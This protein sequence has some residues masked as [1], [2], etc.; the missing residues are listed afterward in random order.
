MVFFGLCKGLYDSNIFAALFDH[1]PPEARATAAG[2]MNTV[3]WS[4]GALGPLAIGFMSKYG[5]YATEM[6]NMSHGIAW[7]GAI[8]VLGGILLIVAVLTGAGSVS[9]QPSKS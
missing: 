2:L 9:Q 3:G 4:G 6:Q 7:C 1:I 5:P 8:Y